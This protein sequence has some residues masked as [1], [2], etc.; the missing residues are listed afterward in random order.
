MKAVFEQQQSVTISSIST[1]SLQVNNKINLGEITFSDK[2]WTTYDI[3]ENKITRSTLETF[4]RDIN[5]EIKILDN[6]IRYSFYNLSVFLYD[7]II[8]L[9]SEPGT[10]TASKIA[11]FIDYNA[12]LQYV[13]SVI[14][15]TGIFNNN[16]KN[17]FKYLKFY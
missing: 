11:Y 1:I 13:D 5:F 3:K 7:D 15:S 12:D 14:I 4:L 10:Y 8:Y 6:T 9:S 16:D 17:K 2:T